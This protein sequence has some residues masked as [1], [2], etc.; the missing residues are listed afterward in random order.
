MPWRAGRRRLGRWISCAR[1]LVADG[2]GLETLSGA[3]RGAGFVLVLAAPGSALTSG[4]SPAAKA[5]TAEHFRIAPGKLS[6]TPA[7]LVSASDARGF[8]YA[9]LELTERVRF[10]GA[11][12]LRLNEHVEE[13]PA[14]AVRSVARAFCSEI[15]DKAWY[16]DRDFWHAYLDNLVACRFNRFNF[17]FGIA[18]D[19]PRG[20]T[21]DYFHF[22]YPYLV[23]V[24]GYDV[25]AVPL[26]DGER[27]RN[28]AMLQ[29]I[30]RET[31]ARGLDFQLGLWTHAYQWTDSPDSTHHITGLT[32]QSHAPYCRDA[33][34][35]LLKACPEISGLTM[36]IH[37]ESGIPEGS[38]DFWQ[39][40]FDAIPAA[41]RTINID[42]HAKGINQIMIDMG[43]KTGMPVTLGAK[44]SAEHQSLGYHQADIR[45]VE[46]PRP[47]PATDAVFAVSEGDRRFTRY[48]YAD[49]YQDGSKYDVLYRL[50]PG[51]QHHLLWG[52]PAQAAAFGRSAHFCGAAG[53]EL[54]EPL[55]F[56]GREGSG[57]PGGRCAYADR[58]LDPGPNDFS[59]FAATYRL[60]GRLLYNPNAAP[61][62]WRRDLA[63]RFGSSA[64]A[65]EEALANASR[66]L[67]LLTSAHLPSASNHDLEYEIAVNMPIVADGD[68][69]YD[70]TPEPKVYGHASPLDPQLFSTIAEH[71]GDVMAGR[72]NGKYSPAEVAAWLDGFVSA[73]DK[74][75]AQARGGVTDDAGLRRLTEDVR[76]VG[77]MGLFYAAKLRA[78]LLFEVWSQTHDTAAGKLAVANYEKARAAWA[79]MAERAKTVYVADI[80]YGRIQKRRGHWADRLAG[81]DKDIAAMR[82]AVVAGSPRG[83]AGPALAAIPAR[84]APCFGFDP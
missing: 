33:L 47:G 73:S 53:L 76:I 8:V 7:L 75:L 9:L 58:T 79:A 78:A 11:V 21:D 22:P 44:Y 70:D 45:P 54:M 17:S 31:V 15:E 3:A 35:V 55:T 12:A 57:H 59:K 14:N 81:I 10:G 18:Y 28:L 68:V 5:A 72:A 71:A 61:D 36:R 24:P 19:F 69:P 80:S 32:P 42:M 37:G 26:A 13:A 74:A 20:V 23:S 1:A 34:A 52:D 48:G 77:G 43:A 16:Y 46:I 27:E 67:P 39:T 41:G 62:A 83:E 38:Y 84:A 50:W 56:K 66:V 29:F 63:R 30:A 49:L 40:L 6:G 60:W 4:F 64:R 25:K 65:A 82:A 2:S 51:T